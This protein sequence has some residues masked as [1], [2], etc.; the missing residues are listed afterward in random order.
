MN[1][2][3]VN[4]GGNHNEK[5]SGNLPPRND[6]E[7]LLD[8]TPLKD[9]AEAK[10]PYLLLR[11]AKMARNQARLT[12]LG[13]LGP[14]SAEPTRPSGGGSTLVRPSRKRATKSLPL[15]DVTP[16]VLRRSARRKTAEDAPLAQGRPSPRHVTSGFAFVGENSENQKAHLRT[17]V[18]PLE[19]AELDGASNGAIP[20]ART[21]SIDVRAVVHG[22]YHSPTNENASMMPCCILGRKLNQTGKYPV[23][24]YAV[25]STAL[26]SMSEGEWGSSALC[27]HVSMGL[28]YNKY[29][30]VQ[31]WGMGGKVLFLWVNIGAPDSDV[32]ND[33]L[34][35][36]R[37]MTWFGGSR[38][39]DNS[40]PIQRLID[41][42]KRASAGTLP[43]TD[44]IIL[45]VR[46][47]DPRRKSFGPYAC[48]GRVG[49]KS[50]T[51]GTRPLQFVW[52]LLDYDEL[53]TKGSGGNE[54]GCS[55]TAFQEIITH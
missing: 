41:V 46:L 19:D 17:T 12:Q 31:E 21:T 27:R 15:S 43:T 5:S 35:G 52:D 3:D 32:V 8:N 2:L 29:C 1:S 11:A 23:I 42:G 24:Q 16:P 55:V 26:S 50:H 53:I 45:W 28:S 34:D 44:G 18:V 4:N 36:G 39:H 30:G 40:R 37:R 14:S 20:T 22:R 6:G 7:T 10:N 47:F 25:R 54:G 13:L 48:L 9:D 49:Y 33:F 51:P 38:M